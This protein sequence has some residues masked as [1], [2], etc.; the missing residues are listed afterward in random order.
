MLTEIKKL[1]LSSDFEHGRLK[2]DLDSTDVIV[3]LSNGEK[4]AASFFSY[5]YVANWKITQKAASE[6]F[7]GKIF[8][9]PNMVIVDQC[10][11]ENIVAIIQYLIDEG[12]FRKAFRLL[13]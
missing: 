1:Y 13:N 7:N 12:D 6:N 2:P 9:V 10:T 4:H 11:K 8:W 3:Q 5:A